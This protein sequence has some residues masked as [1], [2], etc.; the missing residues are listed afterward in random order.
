MTL[1]FVAI[2]LVALVAHRSGARQESAI[3][4]RGILA[5]RGILVA[6]FV[7]TFAVVWLAWAS[8]SPVAV[9]HDEMAYVLQ[10]E[11]FVKQRQYLL[12]TVWILRRIDMGNQRL[13]ISTT[14]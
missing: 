11:I 13:P 14:Y 1:T 7:A 8:W 2:L 9:V 4:V 3:T 6:V 10:A 12:G 5:S